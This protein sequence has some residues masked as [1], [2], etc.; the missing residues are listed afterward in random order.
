VVPIVGPSLDQS[1]LSRLICTVTNNTCTLCSI[2]C[3]FS[4]TKTIRNLFSCSLLVCLLGAGWFDFFFSR[5]GFP[6]CVHYMTTRGMSAFHIKL[7]CVCVTFVSLKLCT[8]D[9]GCYILSVGIAALEVG[10][11]TRQAGSYRKGIKK[12]CVFNKRN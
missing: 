3:N 9:L 1:V 4:A 6:F 2:F 7:G 5:I 12:F 8:G 11:A 10:R